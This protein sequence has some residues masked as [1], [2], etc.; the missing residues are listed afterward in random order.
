MSKPA[1]SAIAWTN[2]DQSDLDIAYLGEKITA[3]ATRI[4]TIEAEN[5][6]LKA[7]ADKLAE[8]LEEWLAMQPTTLL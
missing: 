7:K 2:A 8:V 4:A 6:A 1:P 5:A 3:E